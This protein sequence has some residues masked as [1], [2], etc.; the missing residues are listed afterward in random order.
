MASGDNTYEPTDQDIQF[1]N[2]LDQGYVGISKPKVIFK[3]IE[4]NLISQQEALEQDGDYMP[5]D[6][7]GWE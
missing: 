2:E 5:F 6:L 7:Q 4:S 1:L 3:R